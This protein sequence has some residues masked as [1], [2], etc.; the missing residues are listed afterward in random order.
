MEVH[1]MATKIKLTNFHPFILMHTAQ[2]P[3]KYSKYLDE[4][5]LEASKPNMSALD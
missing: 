4:L 5:F 2:L 3:Q 1:A